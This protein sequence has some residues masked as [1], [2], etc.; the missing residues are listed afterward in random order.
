VHGQRN[1][2]RIAQAIH[3]RVAGRYIFKPKIPLWVNFGA[4]CNGRFWYIFG[5]VA[6]F[7]ANLCILWSFGIF[8]GR[9]VYFVVVW[10][11]FPRFGLLYQEKSGN[12]DPS[13]PLH[14]YLVN[15][16]HI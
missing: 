4:V 1:L 10:Y 5:H 8:C 14:T 2:D 13:A 11:I 3:L 15:K 12:P 6:Y 16:W 7:T 9:L